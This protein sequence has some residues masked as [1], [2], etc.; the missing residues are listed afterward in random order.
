MSDDIIK[1]LNAYDEYYRLKKK[2]D[3]TVYKTIN[4]IKQ[5]NRY[6]KYEKID[7]IKNIN[8]K[9]VNCN[10]SGGS[11]FTNNGNTLKVVCGSKTPCPLHIEL[12]KNN[13]IYI[14]NRLIELNKDITKHKEQIIQIKLDLIFGLEDEN[15]CIKKFDDEREDILNIT[16]QINEMKT[17]LFNKTCVNDL[18]DDNEENEDNKISKNDYMYK[19]NKKLDTMVNNYK[20]YIKQYRILGKNNIDKKNILSDAIDIYIKQ[21][22]KFSKTIMDNIYDDIYMDGE[23]LNKKSIFITE[24]NID[25]YNLIKINNSLDNLTIN[26]GYKVV[27]FIIK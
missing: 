4:K 8:K 10:K 17:I 14:P 26:N 22:D 16:K 2:Y 11:I 24:K 9:C 5:N 19:S 20:Q 6:E 27:S 13:S 3:D 1:Y 23:Y 15:I 12:E 7:K 25:T 18:T 21:I